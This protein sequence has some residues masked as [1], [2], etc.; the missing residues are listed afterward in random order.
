MR[1]RPKISW[2]RIAALLLLLTSLLSA[3]GWSREPTAGVVPVYVGLGASDAVGVGATR[4]Q[5]EGWVPLV[6]TGLSGEVELLNL[7]VSG[8][9][10]S[11]VIAGQLP[12]ALDRAPRW[13]TLWPGANDFRNG[14]PLDTFAAQLDQ[15]LTA[16]RPADGRDRLIAV[17]NLPDLRLL[18]VFARVGGGELDARVR[19]WNAVI[20]ATVA[21]HADYAT[22]VDLYAGW[23]EFGA[24]PEY[25]SADGFH[26]SSAGYRR[27]A[28][29]ALAAL[30]T[31]AR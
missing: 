9:M 31:D 19:D 1:T 3:C 20:A 16:L 8:A 29:L 13:V 23:E 5:Q 10:L 26:P 22:L 7:G 11:D 30:R 14:V 17:L 4:P 27:I 21:R 12:V 28:D 18:P 6:A 25:V 24:H 15:I 2:L